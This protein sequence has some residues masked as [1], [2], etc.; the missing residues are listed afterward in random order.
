MIKPPPTLAT[1][2]IASDAQKLARM[3]RLSL[4]DAAAHETTVPPES[5]AVDRPPLDGAGEGAQLAPTAS[6]VSPR[7]LPE[8]SITSVVASSPA[9]TPGPAE[10]QGP[11][12]KRVATLF[13]VTPPAA[14]APALREPLNSINLVLPPHIF[15]A[16]ERAALGRRWTKKCL[17]LA[18]LKQFGVDIPDSALVPDGR[19]LRGRSAR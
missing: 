8:A 14:A 2:G 1:T 10:T 5:T 4:V 3:Q 9:P 11:M 18:A 12:P 7:E 17:I 16:I 6:Q 13:T 15:D 19:K